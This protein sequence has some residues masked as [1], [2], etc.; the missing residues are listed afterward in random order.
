M[1]WL[2]II[3]DIVSYWWNVVVDRWLTG[4]MPIWHT[5]IFRL[6]RGNFAFRLTGWHVAPMGWNL[7]WESWL[8]LPSPRLISPHQCKGGGMG[9]KNCKFYEIWEYKCPQRHISCAVVM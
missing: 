9:R 8:R 6:L 5:P 4:R 7:A 1:N 3:G 2:Q